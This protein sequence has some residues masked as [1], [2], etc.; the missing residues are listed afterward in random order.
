MKLTFFVKD[1]TLVYICFT[2]D[3]KSMLGRFEKVFVPYY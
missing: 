1:W 2:N 3:H